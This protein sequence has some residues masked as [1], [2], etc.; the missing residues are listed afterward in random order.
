VGTG[1]VPDP[2]V[3]TASQLGEAYEGLLIAIPYVHNT[4][5]G[6]DWPLADSSANIAIT[7]TAETDTVTLRIDNDTNIDGWPEP[8]WPK[9]VIGICNQYD[10]SSPY[11]WYYQLLPRDTADFLPAGSVGIV[12][13]IAQGSL[14]AVF[15]LSQNYPNPFNPTTVIRYSLP[16][17]RQGQSGNGG[18]R[19][20]TTSTSYVSLKVYNILGQE[21]RTLV[22]EEQAP[23]NYSVR[24]DGRDNAGR[25]LTSGIYI[26]R[27]QAGDFA[28]TRRMILLK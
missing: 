22:D 13:P 20:R 21:V 5:V 19:A 6:D 16:V 23:G 24:W 7:D 8:S 10:Y 11:T 18:A 12:Q 28:Q 14:P 15:S 1:T 4:G 26:Y 2:V 17:D 27:I 9:D 3:I 25:E